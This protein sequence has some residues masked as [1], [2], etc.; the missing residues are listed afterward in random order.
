MVVL[1]WRFGNFLFGIWPIWAIFSMENP[2]HRLKLYF[3]GRNL[4]KFCQNKKALVWRIGYI[5]I[6][7][8]F[9]RIASTIFFC[10][11]FFSIL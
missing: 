6:G 1:I 11:E 7:R 2:L 4:A 8:T 10:G 3:S 9:G 5:K